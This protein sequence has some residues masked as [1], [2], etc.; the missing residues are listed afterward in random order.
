M[1]KEIITISGSLGGGKSSTA[2]LVAKNLGYQRF[3]SGDFFR[4]IGLELGISVNEANKKAEVDLIMD[5]KTDE[6]VT[7]VGKEMNKFVIDGHIAFYF[8]PESFKV[9]LNLPPEIAKDRILNNLKDNPLRKESEDSS[10]PEEIYEKITKRLVMEKSRFK[11]IYNLEDYTDPKHFDL[12]VDTNKN[13]LEQVVDIVVSE[14]KKW[15]AKS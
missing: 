1:K 14:Y 15:L 5:K 10:T 11:K 7:R 13:N 8:I 4:K 2:D 3:S 9:F 12:V 6:E